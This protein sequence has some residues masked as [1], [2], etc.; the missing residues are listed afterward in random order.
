[1]LYFYS[2]DVFTCLWKLKLMLQR[3]RILLGNLCG[4]Q[5]CFSESPTHPQDVRYYISDIEPPIHSFL[6]VQWMLKLMLWTFWIFQ[7]SIWIQGSDI[8]GES[9]KYSCKLPHRCFAKKKVGNK[10]LYKPLVA[11]ANLLFYLILFSESDHHNIQARIKSWVKT[12]PNKKPEKCI[13]EC[14]M[15]GLPEMPLEKCTKI[16][17]QNYLNSNPIWKSWHPLSP[18]G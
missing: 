13:Q 7:R 2:Q 4:H 11:H 16:F 6:H 1:M 8:V 18:F 14:W 10:K 9:L 5:G 17:L 3:F 12:K 15:S